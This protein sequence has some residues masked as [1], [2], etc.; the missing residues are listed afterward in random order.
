MRSQLVKTFLIL[1]LLLAGSVSPFGNL[2]STVHAQGNYD[3]QLTARA[4]Q[5]TGDDFPVFTRTPNGAR[6]FARISP[7]AE[8]LRSI[9]DGLTELFRVA[10]RHGYTARLDYSYYTIFIARADRT[11]DSQGAYSPDIAV[12][13]G[14]YAGSG[15]DQGGYI[16]AAGMVLA[17]NPCAFIIAE[18]ER[19]LQRISN[20]V[21]YE[22]EHLILYYNDRALYEKT[23]DHSRGGGHPILQ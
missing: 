1:T 18:H 11:K 5:I 20:V 10:R 21:R 16:Y 7:R 15:Y 23:A 19:D 17:F 2:A 3:R 22:G 12:P 8:V 9:D 4:R 13:A 6:V 14:Q